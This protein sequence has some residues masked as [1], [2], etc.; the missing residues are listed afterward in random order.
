M[1]KIDECDIVTDVVKSVNV[2][3][4]LRWVAL[5]WNSVKSGR[6]VF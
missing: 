1:S 4:A 2:L 5:A 3:V 6:L